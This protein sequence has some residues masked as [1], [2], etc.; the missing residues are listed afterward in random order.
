MSSHRHQKCP[1]SLA[2]PDW[3]SLVW[4]ASSL[5]KHSANRFAGWGDVVMF[6]ACTA[7]RIGEVSGVR[8]GDID[9]DTWTWTVRR[10]T[11]PGPGGLVDKGTKGKRARRVPL[12]EEIREMVGHR[13]DQAKSPTRGCSPALAAGAS[14]RPCSATPPTGTTWWPSSGSSTYAGT[15]YGTPG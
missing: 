5:V 9:R 3:D 2:L 8:A 14:A 10:Q 6:A 7:A 1:R 13:L 11:T 12:I 4:L 15:T